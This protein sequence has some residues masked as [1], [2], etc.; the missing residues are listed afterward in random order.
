M[1]HFSTYKAATATNTRHGAAVILCLAALQQCENLAESYFKEGQ[2]MHG[3]N[4]N[5][6]LFQLNV[7]RKGATVS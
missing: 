2:K 7:V 4:R 6:V 1:T 5:V 3:K